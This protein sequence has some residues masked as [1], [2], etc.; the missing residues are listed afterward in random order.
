MPAHSI[1]SATISFGLVSVPIKMFSAGESSAAISFNW[2]HKKDGSRLKQQYVCSKDGEKVEKED[3]IKGYE[4]AKGRYVQFTPDELKALEE[5]GTGSINI[6]EFVDADTV[7]RMYMD[8]VYFM[9]PDKG[10]DRAFTLLGEALKKTRKVAIGQW[11]A[12]GKQYLVD[13]A[14]FVGVAQLLQ[15]SA[16]DRRGADPEG[17]RQEGGAGHGGAAR[18]AGGVGQVRAPEVRGHGQ[19]AHPG[20]DPAQSGGR[21]DHRGADRSPQDADHRPHGGAQG[22]SRQGQRLDRRRTQARQAH[23]ARR[24]GQA[25]QEAQGRQRVGD[26]G[27]HHRGGR[28]APRPFSRADPI[29]HPSRISLSRACRAG[30]AALFVSGPGAAARGERADG[31]PHPGREDPRLAA[32]AETAAAAGT[33]AL[34]TA[35]HSR[36]T[37]GGRARRCARLE[38][39]FGAAGAR[40]RRREP[41]RACGAAGA[42]PGG[43]RPAR[44]GRSRR[45]AVVRPR[46]R[47]GSERAG[48]RARR[49]PAGA[50]ARSPSCRRPGE[51]GTATG[52]IRSR[53][54]GGDA[55]P[56]GAGRLSRPRDRVVQ[57]RHCAGGPA[58]PQRR[59][60]GLRAGDRRRSAAGGRVLQPGAAVRAGGEEGGGAA[61]LVDLSKT[62]GGGIG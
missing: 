40:L 34:G 18:R 56:G 57:P 21:G 30:R 15:R 31:G 52:R 4:F 37:S 36:G 2:L 35:H 58:A 10:G 55:F 41:G 47:A 14:H 61:A 8:K 3:M 44:G 32:P 5:K 9:G 11:A 49:L 19:D 59:G 43:G 28:P 46:A 16:L 25:S 50:R 6:T 48:G 17:R 12:R 23:R 62:D 54:G 26:D 7:D 33:G 53:R 20:A 13:R 39:G 29:L 27:I 38:S 51:P 22:E 45:R 42:P 1:G 60:E 24:R